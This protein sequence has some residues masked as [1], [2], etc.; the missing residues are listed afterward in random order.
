M[1]NFNIQAVT[2]EPH[3]QI[4]SFFRSI[5][6]FSIK[7]FISSSLR[8]FFESWSIKSLKNKFLLLGICPDLTSCLG[9]SEIPK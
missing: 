6:D 7:N 1:A 9:S 4:I 8:N 3:E 2:P 5:S